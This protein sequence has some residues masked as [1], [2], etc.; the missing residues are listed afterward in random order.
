MDLKSLT[1]TLSIEEHMTKAVV[2]CLKFLTNGNAPMIIGSEKRKKIN[3]SR[4]NVE[5]AMANI[6]CTPLNELRNYTPENLRGLL[7]D[8]CK[9]RTEKFDDKSMHNACVET[10][11][12][13]MHFH[14]AQQLKQQQKA[15]EAANKEEVTDTGKY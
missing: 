10:M 12:A 2:V 6:L 14:K 3:L 8:D 4:L 15:L 13:M 1:K 11:M 9:W 7:R 5:S